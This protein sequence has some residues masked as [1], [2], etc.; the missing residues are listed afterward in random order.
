M[1]TIGI[2]EQIEVRL[3]KQVENLQLP[4]PSLV[5]F[6]NNLEDRVVWIDYGIDEDILEVSRMI[7][8]WNNEDK[9]IPIEERQPIKLLLYSYGGDGQACF[10][11]LDIIGLSKTPIYT[12]NM[13]VSMSAGL[14]ILLAGHKRFCLPH[15]IALAH[16]GS[17]GTQ[18]TYEQTEAQMKDYQRFVKSMRDYI[19]ERTNIDAKTLSKNKGKEWYMYVDDQIKYHIVDKVVSDIDEIC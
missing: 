10:S 15:S 8:R 2:P 9:N 3:P 17:G 14:L 7:L 5:T 1:K 12:I 6:Y 19:L 16:S 18:G 13:G 11:L 4:D